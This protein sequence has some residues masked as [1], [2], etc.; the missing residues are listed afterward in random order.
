MAC[1]SRRSGPR[2]TCARARTAG[3]RRG[4]WRS[5]SPAAARGSR[6]KGASRIAC[7]APWGPSRGSRSPSTTRA[8]RSRATRLRRCRP[9]A[10][11]RQRVSGS[12]CAT[13][14]CR[15][16][17]PP[18]RRRIRRAPGSLDL[19]A[20]LATTSAT[21][22]ISLERASVVLAEQPSAPFMLADLRLEAGLA[23]EKPLAVSV[24]AA[25]PA[26]AAGT[27]PGALELTADVD[28]LAADAR[29]SG[30]DGGRG[31]VGALPG[32]GERHRY[33]G[34][35]RAARPERPLA[36]RARGHRP[37]RPSPAPGRWP[38]HR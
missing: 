30:G 38:R 10:R 32:Q 4:R 14:G 26:S 2:S 8:P 24:A 33:G 20:L 3:S 9:A 28:G 34:P 21:V 25:L 31:L 17:R 6:F 11:S 1:S 18:I 29:Q 37:R 12:R 13:S 7:S 22:G 16:R 5:S 27:P 36:R 23:P 35:R 15:C 19:G